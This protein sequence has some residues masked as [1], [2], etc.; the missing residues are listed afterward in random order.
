MAVFRVFLYRENEMIRRRVLF[1]GGFEIR[2]KK[3]CIKLSKLMFVLL[4]K[5]VVT[6]NG[7]FV[8]NV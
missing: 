7:N 8:Q 5:S 2:R 1:I 3:N 6:F 4:N